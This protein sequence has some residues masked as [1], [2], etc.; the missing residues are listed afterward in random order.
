MACL[1]EVLFVEPKDA[2]V[3]PYS[4]ADHFKVGKRISRHPLHET[5]LG[6]EW[7]EKKLR[8]EYYQKSEPG[9][10]VAEL[11]APVDSEAA[12]E[13]EDVSE[14]L[15]RLQ[16]VFTTPVDR[17]IEAWRDAAQLLRSRNG[18]FEQGG[19]ETRSPES[20]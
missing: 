17:L 14:E 18:A 3:L 20:D 9:A 11:D 8:D 15:S 19:K 13:C 5:F 1:T 2:K 4:N 6:P 7:K 16:R 12:L 10:L